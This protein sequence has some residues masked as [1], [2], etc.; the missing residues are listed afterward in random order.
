MLKIAQLAFL[1]LI[2]SLAFMKES[3]GIGGLLATPTDL[4]FLV[5][6]AALGLA[7][8][9]G[10]TTLRWNRFFI[11]LIVYFAAIA[12]SVLAS[13]QPERGLVKLASQLYL[14][15]LPLLAFTLIDSIERLRDAAD[16]AARLAR[17]VPHARRRVSR[18]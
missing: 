9:A 6:A 13:A 1:L 16:R 7:V 15:S 12:V 8:V 17:R 5:T 2:F 14:L 4:L 11:V 10:E 18:P 3:Y